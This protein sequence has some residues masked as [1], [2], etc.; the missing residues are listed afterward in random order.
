MNLD[1]VVQDVKDFLDDW[2]TAVMSHDNEE[3]ESLEYILSAI[4]TYLADMRSLYEQGEELESFN[5][6]DRSM[7]KVFKK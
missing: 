3:A 1:E 5:E 6:W 7:G 2:K 4:G